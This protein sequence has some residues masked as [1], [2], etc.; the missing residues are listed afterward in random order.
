MHYMPVVAPCPYYPPYILP[1]ALPKLL[2]A[3][4]HPQTISGLNNDPMDKTFS[5]N[6]Y[7]NP[8]HDMATISYNLPTEMGNAQLQI[9]N[10]I[11][12]QLRVI[13]LT[14][15]QQQIT[16]EAAEL[17]SGIYYYSVVSKGQKL[18]DGKFVVAK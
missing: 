7:P 17:S 8:F 15:G 9:F 4:I 18:G 3:E 11:G 6:I 5:L 13:T 10:N 12:Q 14:Q 16:I 1:Y 2:V